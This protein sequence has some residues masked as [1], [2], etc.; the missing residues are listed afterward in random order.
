M[1]AGPGRWRDWRPWLG[2]LLGVG[3]T[4]LLVLAVS[5]LRTFAGASSD[6]S[7]PL[8]TP[9][10]TI[11][12]LAHAS[13][14]DLALPRAGEVLLTWLETGTESSRTALRFAH[15]EFAPADGATSFVG[16]TI[17]ESERLFA[18]WADFPR[19]LALTELDWLVCFLERLGDGKYDYG[20]RFTAT[21]DAGA[22]WSEPR[23]LHDHVGP[24]EHGFVSLA[25][26]DERTALAV[27]LDGRDIR[28]TENGPSG[29]MGLRMRRIAL[30]GELGP[31]T[32]LDPRVCDC[33]QTDVAVLDDGTALVAYRD[34]S[35]DEVRDIKVLRIVDGT[36]S[37]E[38]DS[39]DRF[40]FE[41]CP[42]NGPALAARGDQVALVW[43]APDLA[44]G[45]RVRLAT[46][47]NRGAD[48]SSTTTLD[49]S[50]RGRVDV[51]FAAGSGVDEP[52]RAFAVWL[53][54]GALRRDW[55]S[56]L[57]ELPSEAVPVARVVEVLDVGPACAGR[58]SGFPRAATLNQTFIASVAAE[59]ETGVLRRL[60][61]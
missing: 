11:G 32:L 51:V 22:T 17:V 24:G 18:N 34:R 57:I 61:Q 38:F 36:A 58:E 9:V 28:E 15:S 41:G 14:V 21:R 35:E 37:L 44:G 43:Y 52:V 4:A 29:S 40:R 54:D 7:A 5:I 2:V 8:V 19:V 10:K 25:R 50:A 12:E 59:A 56:A 42:V 53:G 47:R 13:C 3:C 48:F 60:G 31:E 1:E 20:V 30:D 45:G 6:S 55:R 46:S 26:I 39:L 49:D 33:C 16:R 27:W 23:W